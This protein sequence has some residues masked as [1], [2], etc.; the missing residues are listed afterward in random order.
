MLHEQLVVAAV[1][2]TPT[3]MIEVH[4]ACIF[5]GILHCVGCN[6]SVASCML[7]D[8]VCGMCFPRTLAVIKIC[9]I[10]CSTLIKGHGSHDIDQ[11]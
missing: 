5:A 11:I 6:W 4:C 8:V 3:L 2:I 10:R 1:A 9:C 7:D